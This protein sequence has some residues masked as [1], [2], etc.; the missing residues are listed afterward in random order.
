MSESN[1][2]Q[3]F[4]LITGDVVTVRFVA[5]TYEEN[6]RNFDAFMDEYY[7]PNPLKQSV[8]EID[9]HNAEAII[10]GQR[11][12]CI[13]RDKIIGLIAKHDNDISSK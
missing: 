10:N 8:I 13:Q 5:K 3:S 1:F 2:Y 6:E 11:L 9:G 7:S 4:L 12:L